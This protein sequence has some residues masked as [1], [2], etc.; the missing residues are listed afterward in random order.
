M[1]LMIPK[2]TLNSG[3]DVIALI[4]IY[5]KVIQTDTAWSDRVADKNRH[6]DVAIVGDIGKQGFWMDYGI[7]IYQYDIRH[8]LD[9]ITLGEIQ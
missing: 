4:Q 3:Q 2:G 7:K 9:N 1:R 8:S 6:F 5:Y